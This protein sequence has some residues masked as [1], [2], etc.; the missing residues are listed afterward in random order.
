MSAQ[1]P[2]VTSPLASTSNELAS[3]RT[4][5]AFQRTRLAADRTL[6]AVIRTSLSLLS[7][8]FTIHKVF[9]QLKET[10]MIAHAASGRNFGL[11]LA[12]IGAL[13]LTMGIVYHAWFMHALRRQ[14]DAMRA[15][16]VL[17]AQSPF[18]PSM[19]LITALLL[20]ALGVVTVVSMI[21]RVGPF[22]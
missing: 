16:G 6:M 2:A 19:T 14:R 20:L 13:V 11:S 4:G 3:R 12:L 17:H 21:Y 1:E 7:F 10:G 18:P 15:E 8:G 9:D 5:M 22:A